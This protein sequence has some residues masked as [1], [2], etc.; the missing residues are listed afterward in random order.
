MSGERFWKLKSSRLACRVTLTC[1]VFMNLNFNFG[2]VVFPHF[3]PLFELFWGKEWFCVSCLLLVQ[4]VRILLRNLIKTLHIHQASIVI[5]CIFAARMVPIWFSLLN[6][7]T[8][9]FISRFWLILLH[10]WL[11]YFVISFFFLIDLGAGCDHWIGV[12]GR[13]IDFNGSISVVWFVIIRDIWCRNH[14]SNIFDNYIY[15]F[16]LNF[17]IILVL[18]WLNLLL[19]CQI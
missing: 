6:F 7:T 11:I 5:T 18:L 17:L 16:L 10:F 1:I 12:Y 15:V 4:I 8:F 9:Y 14:I 19:F 3:L 13:I 2:F